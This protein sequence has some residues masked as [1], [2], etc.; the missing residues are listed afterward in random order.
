MS[1]AG[2][3]GGCES[4]ELERKPS[5]TWAAMLM[6]PALINVITCTVFFR[7]GFPITLSAG[8]AAGAEKCSK[9]GRFYNEA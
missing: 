9:H 6:C 5:V 4:A 7:Q 2:L 8:S 3:A 1:A